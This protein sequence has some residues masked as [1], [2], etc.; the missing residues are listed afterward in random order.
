MP[1]RRSREKEAFWRLALEAH[2]QSGLSVR[3]FCSREGFS[4]AS[5]YAWK[6]TLRERDAG[7]PAAPAEQ[8]ELTPVEIVASVGSSAGNAQGLTSP[9]EV[10][11]PSGYAEGR[12]QVGT[13]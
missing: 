4:T 3:K 10:I 6:R 9:L 1:K 5:S 2:R 11:T 8:A 7:G 13:K 12:H